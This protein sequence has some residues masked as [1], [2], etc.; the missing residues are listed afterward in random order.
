MATRSTIAIERKDGSVAQIYCHWDGYLENNGH[1][2]FENYQDADKV[3]QLIS[4]GDLSSLGADLDSC[5]FYAHD[6]GE[7]G[8]NARVFSNFGDY[9]KNRQ[10]E[11]YEYVL[12]Q[13]NKW[14]M[15]GPAETSEYEMLELALALSMPV[16][17]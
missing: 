1:I 10:I 17:P 16:G 5:V 13:D 7:T 3:E 6:R 11:E 14:Y 2:L 9:V 4:L 8:T 15:K 12:R